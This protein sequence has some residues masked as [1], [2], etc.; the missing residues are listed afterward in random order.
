MADQD[1]KFDHIPDVHGEE[2]PSAVIVRDE[3]LPLLPVRD[4]VLFPRAVMPLNIGREASIE[5]VTSL[6]E[7]KRIGVVTQRDPRVDEPG[8]EELYGIGTLGLIHKV[9]RMPNRS[10]L[11]FCEGISRIRVT[12]YL[13]QKPFMR[14]RY[15]AIEERVPSA[16][17]LDLS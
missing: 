2:A 4:T 8:P 3:G 5:L 14:A 9:V 7:A 6:G 16:W 10:L 13:E 1:Q 17:V 15:E 11:I 12:D